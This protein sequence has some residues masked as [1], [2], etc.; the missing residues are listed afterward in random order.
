[1]RIAGHR[2][3]TGLAHA[4]RG[5]LAQFDDKMI[6]SLPSIAVPTLVLVGSEDVKFHAAADYMAGKIASAQKV[7]IDGAGHEANMDQPTAFNQAMGA[8]LDG[9][10]L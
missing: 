1:M 10:A 6:Q 8:F 2:D 5:M 3:A 4:A 7:V 9:L